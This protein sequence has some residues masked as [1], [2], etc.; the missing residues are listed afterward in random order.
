MRAGGGRSLATKMLAETVE[1]RAAEAARTREW[2]KQRQH[3]RPGA[4]ER[5]RECVMSPIV[6][7]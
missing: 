4:G 5:E 6:S 7:N 1:H 2:G 3:E